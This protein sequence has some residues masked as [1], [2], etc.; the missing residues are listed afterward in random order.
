MIRT[1]HEERTVW[2]S[3]PTRRDCGL[4]TPRPLTR[5]SHAH[6]LAGWLTQHT[7][8]LSSALIRQ[9]GLGDGGLQPCEERPLIPIREQSA[10]VSPISPA[11]FSVQRLDHAQPIG[12]RPLQTLTQSMLV[13]TV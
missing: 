10:A 8:D 3:L 7:I 2:L 12:M 6:P 1:M 4:I 13:Q 9:L 5:P 11:P